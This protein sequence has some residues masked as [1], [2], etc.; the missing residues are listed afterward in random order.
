MTWQL[1]S[2]LTGVPDDGA[3][4]SHCIFTRLLSDGILD[5][6]QLLSIICYPVCC[7]R[8][9]RHVPGQSLESTVAPCSSLL[10]AALILFAR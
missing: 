3:L 4:M 2:Y 8:K 10:V 6:S 9:S 7:H 1:C 5:L